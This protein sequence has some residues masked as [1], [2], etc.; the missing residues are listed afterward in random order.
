[1]AKTTAPQ[2]PVLDHAATGAPATR[3]L[4]GDAA[5]AAAIAEPD[6][7]GAALSSFEVMLVHDASVPFETPFEMTPRDLL[8]A[9]LYH[10]L[11]TPFFFEGREQT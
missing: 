4:R 7:A 10:E 5:R 2:L 11:A 6:T 1:M 3:Q 9:G 8:V